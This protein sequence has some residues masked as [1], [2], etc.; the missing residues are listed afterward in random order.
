MYRDVYNYEDKVALLSQEVERLTIKNNQYQEEN[1]ELKKQIV[2]IQAELDH[3]KK[4]LVA[5]I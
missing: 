2:Y 1:A 3:A 5:Y 4:N